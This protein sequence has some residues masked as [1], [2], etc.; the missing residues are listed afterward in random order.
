MKL[1]KKCVVLPWERYNMLM[2]ASDNQSN[3]NRD[4][5]IEV[6]KDSLDIEDESSCAEKGRITKQIHS[7]G[8]NIGDSKSP[9][10]QQG[11]GEVNTTDLIKNKTQQPLPSSVEKAELTQISDVKPPPPGL[12]EKRKDR[13]LKDTQQGLQGKIKQKN[14]KQSKHK[15]KTSW[16]E[17]WKAL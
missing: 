17:K 9:D 13:I 3:V 8:E 4:E 1:V 14:K 10:K 11:E 7:P 2:K 16:K 12:P 15:K 6:T 5:S